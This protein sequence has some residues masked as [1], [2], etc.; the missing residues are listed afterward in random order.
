MSSARKTLELLSFFSTARPEIGLSQLCRIAGRDKATTYRHLQALETAGFVEQNPVTRQYRLGP[1]VMQLAQVR[2]ATVPRKASAQLPMTQLADVTGETAHVSVLSGNTLYALASC[3]SPKHGTR[4]VIDI[5]TFPLHATASGIC[6]LAFGPEQ[7]FKSATA[8]MTPYTANTPVTPDAVARLVE[9]ARATGFARSDRSFEAEIHSLSAPIYDQ[10]GLF[11]GAV[12]V[13]CVASRF[14]PALEHD[15]KTQLV[16]ASR[17]ITRNWGGAL[18]PE[19]ETA[20][21]SSLAPAQ[22]LDIAK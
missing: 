18:P 6:A 5:T 9:D 3:E 15:I 11:A 1:A 22:T 7:L 12:S 20:W 13:A 10:T 17:D 4:A 21:A 19:I 16:T 2:E 8:R 14:T